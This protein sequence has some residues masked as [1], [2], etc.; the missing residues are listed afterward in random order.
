MSLAVAGG[1]VEGTLAVIGGY[2]RSVSSQIGPPCTLL[3]STP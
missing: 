3:A 2:K 1:A